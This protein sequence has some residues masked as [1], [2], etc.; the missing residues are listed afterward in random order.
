MEYVEVGGRRD[1]LVCSAVMV[2]DAM[3]GAIVGSMVGSVDGG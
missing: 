2:E 3:D 1:D